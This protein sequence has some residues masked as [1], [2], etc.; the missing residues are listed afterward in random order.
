MDH[1]AQATKQYRDISKICYLF[2]LHDTVRYIDIETT[3]PIG[4]VDMYT[5][6]TSRI[7]SVNAGGLISVLACIKDART[8]VDDATWTI[9]FTR[10]RSHAEL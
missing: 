1:Q 3:K 6:V 10:S 2:P 7:T 9:I 8:N 5:S 4:Y